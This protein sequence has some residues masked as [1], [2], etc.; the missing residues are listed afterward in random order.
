MGRGGGNPE[1]HIRLKTG[2][3]EGEIEWERI[4]E[5]LHKCLVDLFF[6]LLELSVMG[7]AE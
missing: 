6:G 3:I 2:L 1:Y 7:E 4:N 5:S